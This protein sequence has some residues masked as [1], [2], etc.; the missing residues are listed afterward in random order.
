MIAVL[1]TQ[2]LAFYKDERSVHVSEG[3]SYQ[4]MFQMHGLG[5]CMSDDLLHGLKAFIIVRSD[6]PWSD[7]RRPFQKST[8]RVSQRQILFPKIVRTPTPR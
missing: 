3:R 8:G 1:I 5:I 4:C 6:A 7:K 2:F